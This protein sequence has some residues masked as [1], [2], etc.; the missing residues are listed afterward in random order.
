MSEQG[1]GFTTPEA[2]VRGIRTTVQSAGLSGNNATMFLFLS[3]FPC[4]DQTDYFLND[5][6]TA[7]LEC[8]NEVTEKASDTWLCSMA[9]LVIPEAPETTQFCETLVEQVL[10]YRGKL[11]A[12]ELATTG[13]QFHIVGQGDMADIPG[14]SFRV[15][16][17]ARFPHLDATFYQELTLEFRALGFSHIADLEE[18]QL[19]ERTDLHTF[20]RYLLHLQT[21]TIAKGTLLPETSERIIELESLMSDGTVICTTVGGTFENSETHRCLLVNHIAG[22]LFPE[23]MLRLHLQKVEDYCAGKPFVSVREVRTLD[24][25]IDLQQLI[26]QLHCET[27]LE[28]DWL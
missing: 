8:E 10:L 6:V 24:D 17:P 21:S 20:T 11:A 4:R 23:E 16:T 22:E 18:E 13:A 12:I 26:A 9:R 2:L 1:L 7:E 19:L 28:A 5:P 15:T 3:E 27:R 14:H 25:V